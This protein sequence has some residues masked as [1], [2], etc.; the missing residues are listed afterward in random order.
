M[1]R[2]AQIFRTCSVGKVLIYIIFSG[3]CQK[4]IRCKCNFKRIYDKYRNSNVLLK[5]TVFAL[6][7]LQKEITRVCEDKEIDFYSINTMNKYL[8]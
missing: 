2:T 5:S 8:H 7:S 6:L 4:S 1:H 3:G